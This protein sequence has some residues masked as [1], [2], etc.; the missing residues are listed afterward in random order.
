MEL[1]LRVTMHGGD[2]GGVVAG[3]DGD[4]SG[5]VVAGDDGD[6]RGDVAVGDDGDDEAVV[7]GDDGGDG[8]DGGTV[9]AD[10]TP[11]SQGRTRTRMTLGVTH[12]RS[13]SHLG[14]AVA[15]QRDYSM[16]YESNRQRII[17]CH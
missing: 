7:M 1:L 5:A 2:D 3:D 13:R 11:V 4:D 6:D 10:K 16:Y 8:G 17:F 12:R 14:R 9:E 15:V